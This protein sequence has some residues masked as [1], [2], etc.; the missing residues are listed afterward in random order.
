MAGLSGIFPWNESNFNLLKMDQDSYLKLA[1]KNSEPLRVSELDIPI[2]QEELSLL[3]VKGMYSEMTRYFLD[4]LDHFKVHPFLSTGYQLQNYINVFVE[5]FLF[6]LSKPDYILRPE[7]AKVLIRCSPVITSLVAISDFETTDHWLK[8]IMGQQQNLLKLLVLY[9]CRNTVSL[10]RKAL[11]DINPY[12]ASLWYGVYFAT[13]VSWQSETIFKNMQE[14][15]S[16][17]DN[18]IL[19]ISEDISYGYMVSTYINPEKDRIYKKNINNLIKKY[20]KDIK[21]IN[22]PDRKKIAVLSACW[23]P[24]HVV[25]RN[26]HDLIGSLKDDY[27]L[28]LVRLLLSNEDDKAEIPEAHWFKD[29]RQVYLVN[30]DFLDFSAVSQNDFIM[31]FYLDI[32]MEPVSI[33]LSNIRLAPVQIMTYGHP[34]STFGSSIDYFIG[35]IDSEVQKNVINYYD[36]RM[37]LTPG[38]GLKINIPLNYQVKGKIK[39]TNKFIINCTWGA[40]KNN[41][42][43][44]TVLQEIARMAEKALLF[45]FFPSIHIFNNYFIPF[46]K[47][48]EKILGTDNVEIFSHKNLESY[49]EM[50]EECDLAIDSHPFGGLNS[51]VDYLIVN[52]PVI[53]WEGWQ[54]YNRLGSVILRKLGLDELVAVDRKDYINKIGRFINDDHLRQKTVEKIKQIDMAAELD[55]LTDIPS[56]KKAIAYLIENHESLKQDN[57]REPIIIK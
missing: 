5:N 14:H 49:L 27:D 16:F 19:L 8:I 17:W 37:V 35:G 6:Y 18:R 46:K 47:D 33:F 21:I 52:K 42:P 50:C 30:A 44:L 32:G 54:F 28:T 55:K 31:A 23:V 24:G 2:N 26:F 53:S 41:Y 25:Y 40:H 10:N 48:I 34:V 43:M 9:N 1:K 51:I 45:R 56:F 38:A 11:F 3:Y 13:S 57:S 15:L 39:K 36:E 7:E 4:I 12:F 20:F 22:K 29:I